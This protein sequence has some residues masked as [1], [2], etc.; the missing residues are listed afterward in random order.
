MGLTSHIRNAGIAG[1]E[2]FTV[3]DTTLPW[4]FA[5]QDRWVSRKW[6]P[7]ETNNKIYYPRPVFS[8]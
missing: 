6:G 4:S 5:H 7:Q 3:T 1:G 8:Q 2:V